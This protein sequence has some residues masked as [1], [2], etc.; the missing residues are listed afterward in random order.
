[1]DVIWIV[2]ML[3]VKTCLAITWLIKIILECVLRKSP[4]IKRSYSRT[5]CILGK[6]W[7]KLRKKMFYWSRSCRKAKERTNSLVKSTKKSKQWNPSARN[8]T[9]ERHKV[10]S[11]FNSNSNDNKRK[12]KL[13]FQLSKLRLISLSVTRSTLRY[14][15]LIS[16]YKR[17]VRKLKG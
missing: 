6:L 11:T 17:S 10:K 15:N 13:S 12:W 2:V 16:N 3:L 4:K 14:L 9:K 5:L 8:E 7:T 1:M